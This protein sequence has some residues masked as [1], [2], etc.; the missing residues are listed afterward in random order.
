[1]RFEPDR[2]SVSPEVR[3]GRKINYNSAQRL[4]VIGYK[5]LTIHHSPLTKC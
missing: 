2:K 5:L 1:M 4:A 3:K